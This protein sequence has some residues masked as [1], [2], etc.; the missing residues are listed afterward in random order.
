VPQLASAPVSR[1]IFACGAPHGGALESTLALARLEAARGREVIVLVASGD[2]YDRMPAVVG[3]LVRLRRHNRPIGELGWWLHDALAGRGAVVERLGQSVRLVADVPSAVRKIVRSEDILVMN[4]LRCVDLERLARLGSRASAEVVWYL[5]ET[6]SLRHAARIDH[7]VD[8]VI[9][10]SRPLAEEYSVIT[11]SSC[12]YVPS[13][14]D[15]SGLDRPSEDGCVLL[16]NATP[17]FGLR[18]AFE[19]ARALPHRRVVL[20]E[21][22]PIEPGQVA[23]LLAEAEHLP[24]VEFRH[25]VAR[26]R[27]FEDAAVLIAPYASEVVGLSRPRVALEAQALGIP[28][29]AYDV[30]GLASV[31]ASREL[32]VPVGSDVSEWVAR[33]EAV[34][35]DAPRF[36]EVARR[37]AASE[38]IDD[39]SLVE[40]FE[41]VIGQHPARAEELDLPKYSAA[42]V[43]FGRVA[44]LCESLAALAGQSVPPSCIVVV[45]NDPAAVVDG[46]AE[47]AIRDAVA[48]SGIPLIYLTPGAN[49]GPSGGWALGAE[50]LR[51]DPARGDWL[52]LIDDDDPLINSCVAAELLGVTITLGQRVVAVGRRGAVVGRWTGLLRRVRPVR[53]AVVDADYLAGNGTPLYRWG[54]IDQSGFVDPDLFFGF[55]DLDL[56]LRWRACGWRLVVFESDVASPPADTASG[57]SAWR[58][59]FK[60]RALVVVCRRHLGVWA[61]L[62]TVIRALVLGGIRITVQTKGLR[63]VRARWAGAIDGVLL[64]LGPRGRAPSTN[65][66]KTKLT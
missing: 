37:F 16:V 10:N 20:Q 53:G 64:R 46:A 40:Q 66:P 15:V 25:R 56:G 58:E 63:C 24:N 42:V 32:L 31:A 38:L 59:Y 9:A 4:S 48:G 14:I 30:P 5:R 62:A 43:T 33:I 61:F 35:A 55:E 29:V 12:A 34:A 8:R 22:W 50:R 54:T 52:M 1:L 19:I 47:A 27:V 49:L 65:P 39:R 57:R 26:E 2:P 6:S 23:T 45:D 44:A 7:V 13:V 11:G 3:L 17:V 21:S 60:T 51:V 18:E 36:A 28:L 41:S